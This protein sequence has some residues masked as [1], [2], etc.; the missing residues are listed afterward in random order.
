MRDTFAK[1][2]TEMAS[3]DHRVTLL[4]GDIGNRMFDKFKHTAP[5]RFFNC[6]IAEA[7]MMSVACGM[8]LKGL[9]PFIYTITPFNTT[10][11]LEQIKVG[12]GY[13]EAPVII[14][15]TGSGLSYAELGATHHSFEDIAVVNVIPNMQIL[16]PADKSELVVHMKE[17]L[18]SGKPTYIRIGKK[19]E[20][21]VLSQD[22]NMGIGKGSLLRD[23]DDIVLITSGPIISEALEAAQKIQDKLNKR[24]AVA[25]I[26]SIKPIDHSLLEMLSTRFATWISVEEHST[27]GG[28]GSELLRWINENKAGVNLAASLGIPDVFIHRLGKQEYMR[29]IIGL[30]SDGITKSVSDIVFRG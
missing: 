14:I 10:R 3:V 8:A 1:I 5:E 30:D 26:G 23:G 24:V 4:S 19:G 29:S 22:S 12:A 17:S 21:D 6:G 9:R 7:N 25:N 28:L 11:C 18:D 2:V 15:G 13:H 27:I 20:P 16:T